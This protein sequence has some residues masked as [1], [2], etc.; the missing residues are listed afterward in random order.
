MS[1]RTLIVCPT[2]DRPDILRRTLA[3]LHRDLNWASPKRNRTLILLDDSVRVS[4]RSSNRLIV[5]EM[6]ERTGISFQYHGP[7]EQQRVLRQVARLANISTSI[8]WRFFR[9]LGGSSWDLGGIR[10]YALIVG[11]AMTPGQFVFI[12]IDDDIVIQPNGCHDNVSFSSIARMERQV[13]ATWKRIVGGLIE[14]TPDESQLETAV[15]WSWELIA[16]DGADGTTPYEHPKHPFPVSGGFFAFP[17]TFAHL[18][19]FPR[20]YNEDW[21]WMV[22]FARQGYETRLDTSVVLKH[23]FGRRELNYHA[24]KLQQEGEALFEAIHWAHQNYSKSYIRRA[25][26]SKSYWS[27]IAR[28]ERKYVD[29]L[30]SRIYEGIQFTGAPPRDQIRRGRLSQIIAFVTSVRA[31]VEKL[32]PDLLRRKVLNYL[33]D[34]MTWRSLVR[35]CEG[36]LLRFESLF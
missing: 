28:E 22:N 25:L 3:A 16:K 24:A 31:E 12:M 18:Y 11:S 8:F 35:A 4:S 15:R 7:G 5:E 34:I 27:E 2:R 26:G 14:G 10:N 6:R 23:V 30:L 29:S 1:V 19:P 32:R 9:R 33:R 20:W 17:G 36:K 13:S 21:T